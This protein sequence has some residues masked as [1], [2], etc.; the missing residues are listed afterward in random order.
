MREAISFPSRCSGGE[1]RDRGEIQL[2]GFAFFRGRAETLFEERIGDSGE[3]LFR[4]VVESDRHERMRDA[5]GEI[6]LTH[7]EKPV[8]EQFAEFIGSC[9]P[10]RTH[11]PLHVDVA[12]RDED[13]IKQRR[14]FRREPDHSVADIFRLASDEQPGA[15]NRDVCKFPPQREHMRNVLRAIPVARARHIGV[16]QV[17]G[18]SDDRV[19]SAADFRKITGGFGIRPRAARQVRMNVEIVHVM[20]LKTGMSRW[21]K[22]PCVT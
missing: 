7:F 13:E 11:E 19:G 22:Q 8:D 17:V 3:Q 15:G 9:H 12:G 2:D 10:L 5:E 18:E 14:M 6:D 1:T 21:K 4:A 16:P 20:S